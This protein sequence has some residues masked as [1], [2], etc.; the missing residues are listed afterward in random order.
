MVVTDFDPLRPKLEW[1]RRLTAALDVALVE[2]D[3]HNI[4]PCRWVSPKR[5]FGAYTLRPKIHR[6][7]GAFLTE[8]PALAKHPWP[9]PRGAQGGRRAVVAAPVVDLLPLPRRPWTV[10]GA[11]AGQRVLTAFVGH[12]LG[13]YAVEHNDPCLDGQSN[14]SPYLHFGQVSA[15]RVALVARRAE[16]PLADD[17]FLE[18]LI[19]RREL[20]DNFCLY[21]PDYDSVT[22]F[23]SWARATLQTHAGD[24]RPYRYTRAQF[25]A[26]ETHDPL[27]NAAQVEMVHGAKMHGYLRM[28]WA[29]K[30]LEW[31]ESVE[32]ALETAIA[33]NDRYEL[34]GRDPNGYTGIAWALGGVHDR[35]WS[36]RPVFGQIRYMNEAGC[37]RKFDVAAY[38]A[39]VARDE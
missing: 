37:R 18:Q 16:V 27:W 20:S 30:T 5:E 6:V 26:A 1:R 9:W 25:E 38:V 24:R 36:E 34:D 19:V 11:R 23:P 3:A 12:G 32:E 29:K 17:P 8:I 7:L 13:R 33:L 31:T 2:V 14:L 39:K 21:A 4:V 28:Y 10:A 22:C 35:P 15:Q